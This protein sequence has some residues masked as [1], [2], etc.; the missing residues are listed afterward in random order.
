MPS[1]RRFPELPRCCAPQ[2]WQAPTRSLLKGRGSVQYTHPHAPTPMGPVTD[3]ALPLTASAGRSVVVHELR[4]LNDLVLDSVNR[5]LRMVMGDLEC[6]STFIHDVEPFRRSSRE[7]FR[8]LL[9]SCL[10]CLGF[11][12]HGSAAC[13]PLFLHIRGLRQKVQWGAPGR[14]PHLSTATGHSRQS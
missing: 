3:D 7:R 12:C 5:P 9:C 6:R 2:W 14:T 13:K 8:C 11:N 10:G 4:I 1:G